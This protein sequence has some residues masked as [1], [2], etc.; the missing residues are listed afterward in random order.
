MISPAEF[1]KAAKTQ[2]QLAFCAAPCK[3]YWIEVA[4]IYFKLNFAGSAMCPVI[5]SS[6][7]HLII[8]D[9]YFSDVAYTIHIWDSSSTK[10]EMPK[11]PVDMDGVEDSGELKG[12]NTERIKSAYFGHARSVNLVDL[13]DREGIVCFHS[14]LQIPAFERACSLRAVFNWIFQYHKKAIVHAA[15]VGISDRAILIVG[16]SG[17]GKSSTA[18]RCLEGGLKYY[19]DDVCV[20]SSDDKKAYVHG[21]YSSGKAFT[22]DMHHFSSLAAA[23]PSDKL[24]IDEK[25][26]FF[27][28]SILPHLMEKK[29]RIQAIVMPHINPNLPIGFEPISYAKVLS[30]LA[31]STVNLMPGLTNNIFLQ[32]KKVAQKAPC[33]QF[34]LGKDTSQI[35]TEIKSFLSHNT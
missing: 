29:A 12:Y 8:E 30:V 32:L 16:K 1:Y 18:L 11:S 10:V 35:A 33:Y 5:L 23:I 20:V 21:L 15:A 9:T 28:N 7:E 14:S 4:G 26:L 17:Y 34:N 13:H 6:I 24:A 2:T 19:G 27:F 3:T 31:S 22:H 25:E